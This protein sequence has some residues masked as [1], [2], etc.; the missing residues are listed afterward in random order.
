LA[1]SLESRL[2]IPVEV[3]L[4]GADCLALLPLASPLVEGE[5]SGVG[6]RTP[7]SRDPREGRLLGVRTTTVGWTEVRIKDVE[8]FFTNCFARSALLVC[9]GGEDGAS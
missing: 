5:T 8:T 2:V 9:G 6:S 4:P 7:L 1:E 3:V